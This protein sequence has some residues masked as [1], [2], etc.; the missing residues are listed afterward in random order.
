[1]D[2]SQD[3][4]IPPALLILV[5]VIL[6]L[7]TLIA[8]PLPMRRRRGGLDGFPF[9]S[10]LILF[11]NV[12]IFFA[13]DMA[14]NEKMVL[15]GA[16]GL[17]PFR[18]WSLLTHQFLHG[19]LEHIVGN[20]VGFWALGTHLEEALG[21]RRYLL[22]YLGGGLAGGLLQ[23]PASG[24]EPLIGASGA[25]FGLMG[26]FAVRFWR[27]RVRFFFIPMPAVLA[28]GIFVAIQIWSIVGELRSAPGDDGGAHVGYFA[29]LGGFL[30]GAGLAYLT[31]VK[32]EGKRE[33][34]IEDAEKAL[35]ERR[36]DD[37][38]S[39]YRRLLLDSPDDPGLHH[40]LGLIYPQVG[41]TADARLHFEK[42]LAL[43]ARQG[44]PEA[45]VRVFYDARQALPQL[46]VTPAL[47]LRIASAAE[48]TDQLELSRFALAEVVEAY[49][50]APE[51]ESALLRLG[52]LLLEKL[53]Q[54]A[55]AAP[56][57][58]EFLRRYPASPN[59]EHAR[60]FLSDAQRAIQ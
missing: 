37:A 16:L 48:Q 58:S 56:L 45:L 39:Q 10:A 5:I 12:V 42:S 34:G 40:T 18:W 57:F 21:R 4:S 50:S 46:P 52:R 7:F 36:M 25:I 2:S 60:R 1:M 8:V 19:G 27:T 32:D 38:L 17:H 30:F 22:Y 3:V 41:R 53:D 44:P 15:A 28:M 13:T 43:Y 31:R 35:R 33:Y 49:P 20:M 55:Q 51:T 14:R 59:A 11:L 26:V 54:P 6:V 24:G 47:L 9:V 29:H 23:L